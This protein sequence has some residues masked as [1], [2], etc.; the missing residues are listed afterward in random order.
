MSPAA[1]VRNLWRFG[2][3][4]WIGMKLARLQTEKWLFNWL[5]PRRGEGRAGRIQQ[6]SLRLTDAC[7]LRCRTCGQWGER[8]FLHDRDLRELRRQELP[9]D[10]YRELLAD[11]VGQGH[12]PLVY[13]WGGEPMLY[14]DTVSLVEAATALRLP[15]SIA[16]NGS[17]V[18]AAAERFAAAPL[19][20][21][22]IS[23]DGHC[24]EVHN[25]IRPSLGG[26]DSFAT[27]DAA[28]DAIREQR[29]ARRSDLPLVAS[30]TVISEHNEGHLVDIYEAFRDRVDVFIFF[31]AWWIDEERAAAHG[32]D[33]QRRFGTVATTQWG[34]TGGWRPHDF[35]SLARQQDELRTMSR[36][37]G[38]PPVVFLPNLAGAAE[39]ERYYTDHRARF[40]FEQ[41]ISIFQAMEITSN[42][43]VTPCRDYTDFVVGNVRESTLTE[44]WNSEPYRRFRSSLARDGLMP[45]CSR[46]CG[47]MG[48]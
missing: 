16:T 39:L 22:E 27:V 20:L 41:C 37:W 46:C 4:P 3:R 21:F 18:K 36:S 8:G 35:G 43:D 47:L 9:S 13:L 10:R 25:R 19:F 1:V 24:A 2:R 38:A 45:V 28:V 17:G 5:H 33:F 30:L 31:L 48:Y 23:I 26:G 42:G 12:A 14:R 11:L 6:L 34:W 32:A 15:V 40:G 29:R 44:I 7:N